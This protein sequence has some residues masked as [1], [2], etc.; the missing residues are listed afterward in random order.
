MANALIKHGIAIEYIDEK[1][2]PTNFDKSSAFFDIFEEIKRIDK[3][4]FQK[5]DVKYSD[6]TW[7]LK[8]LTSD[9]SQKMEERLSL[10]F[11]NIPEPFLDAAK[12]FAYWE[13]TYNRTMKISTLARFI[14]ILRKYFN[15]LDAQYLKTVSI[16]D[17]G[18][19][20]KYIEYLHDSRLS[21]RLI[22]NSV[23]SIRS[24][25]EFYATNMTSNDLSQVIKFLNKASSVTQSMYQASVDNNKTPDIPNEYYNKFISTCIK[26]MDSEDINIDDRC[27]A[28]LFVIASQTGLRTRQLC[29]LKA[30]DTKEMSISTNDDSKKTVHFMNFKVMKRQNGASI[31]EPAKTILNSLGYRAYKLI[32]ELYK[33]TRKKRNIDYLFCSPKSRSKKPISSSAFNNRLLKFF[34]C[35]GEDL[36]AVNVADKYPELS[37]FTIEHGV[38]R[39]Y[40]FEDVASKYKATDTITYP[41]IHQ[42]RVHLCT[43]LYYKQIPLAFIKNFMNHLSEDMTDYYVRRPEYNKQKDEYVNAILTTIVK[44]K[45]AP[46]GPGSDKLMIKIDEFIKKGKFNVEKDIDTIIAKLK[47]KIPI[48]EK[49]GG[50]CIKSGEKR[51]C[52]FD[53][54]GDEFYCA[55]GACPNHFHLYYMADISYT[56]C[57]NLIKTMEHNK[58]NGFVKQAQKEKHKL[59]YVAKNA[60]H[61]ELEQ[62]KSEIT[63]KGSEWIKENHPE[64]ISILDNLETIEKEVE[65]WMKM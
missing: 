38:K 5:A 16:I 27:T 18:T 23:Q 61:P 14:G 12:A 36:G 57:K 48:K 45:I 19:V 20:K 9:E 3:L 15:Y 30:N 53:G 44:D 6:N 21:I 7:D 34:A 65:T 46:L 42:F 58:E 4:P 59:V 60:L 17:I 28:A 43:E 41:C 25:Y 29:L 37:S 51:E 55:Y 64:L 13:L 50:I 62:L 49:Y 63:K 8:D 11:N 10:S 33:E 35:Y 40:L 26:L 22:Y 54:K 52:R 2:I 56:K 39:R 47:K 1:F 32:E 31:T 24:F